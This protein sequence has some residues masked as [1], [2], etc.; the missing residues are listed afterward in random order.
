MGWADALASLGIASDSRSLALAVRQRR[1]G[2]E[3]LAAS[4]ALA[5]GVGFPA[6][7]LAVG[8]IAGHGALR[9]RTG[10]LNSEP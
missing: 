1:P 4:V 10:K 3:S 8:R 5:S 2:S 6:A 9:K 7:W